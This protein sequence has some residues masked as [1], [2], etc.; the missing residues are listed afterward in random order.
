MAVPQQVDRQTFLTNLRKSELV[1]AEQLA[2]VAHRLPVTD[3]GKPLARALVALGLLTK[4]QAERVLAGRTKGFCLGQYRI[5]DQIGQGGMGRVFKAVHQTMNRLVALKVLAP[6]FVETQR[7]QKLFLR[8]MQAAARLTHPNIVTAYDA[9]QIGER[10][11]LVLEYVEGPNLHRLV[12]R[13][14]PLPVGQACDFIRQIAEGLHYAFEMGMVHRDIKP[15]NLLLRPVGEGSRR[16]YTVKI[17]D[18]GLARLHN[19]NPDEPTTAGTILVTRENVLIGTP[20]FVS[21]EQARDLHAADIRS[22]LYSLGCTFYFLLTGR[23][24]FAGG[25]TLEKLIR[26]TTEAPQPI[27]AL[28]PEVPLPVA[29]IVRRLLAKEPNARFQTPAELAR[30]L[31]PFAVEGGSAWSG[32]GAPIP[33]ADSLA[34]PMTAVES[35]DDSHPDADTPSSDALAALASTLPPDL[36][37]TP[38]TMTELLWPGTSPQGGRQPG[39]FSYAEHDQRRRM[40]IA[41]SVAV[42]IVLTLL[43]L[44]GLLSGFGLGWQ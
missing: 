3:R 27:E 12:R 21:P 14:G 4:F 33:T 16:R 11:Y 22:D 9:N 44:A 25:S 26:H 29:A 6:Q 32:L 13:H 15:S 2:A 36:A 41:V 34:P 10:Y 43:L 18:F 8:E 37:P 23:V 28:R 42:G 17:L 38:V 20:D 19:R 31:K 7:A 39:L 35:G 5:L 30:A 1:T 40:G 24:P